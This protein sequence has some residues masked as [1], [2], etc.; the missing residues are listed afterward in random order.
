VN[1]NGKP[2][3]CYV[4]KSN[5]YTVRH[6]A[7]DPEDEALEHETDVETIE[8][9][10]E[11]SPED[12]AGEETPEEEAAEEEAI[13]AV[14]SAPPL[15]MAL[16]AAH[17]HHMALKDYLD[18][19]KDMLERSKAGME[20]EHHA[21]VDQHIAALMEMA[22][23][24][25][26]SANGVGEMFTKR[27]PETD[28][29]QVK[30][31]TAGPSPNQGQPEGLEG[32][33]GYTAMDEDYEDDAV[34]MDE[35]YVSM[36]DDEEE[37]KGEEDAEEILAR[38]REQPK[39]GRRGVRKEYKVVRVEGGYTVVDSQGRRVYEEAM[40]KERAEN[41]AR[42]LQ[43]S[44]G[45][46]ARRAVAKAMSGVQVN[47]AVSVNG[48]HGI[49]VAVD[50]PSQTA[51]VKFNNGHIVTD[52][53]FDDLKWEGGK[54]AR[55]AVAKGSTCMSET[56]ELLRSLAG[57][58]TDPVKRAALEHHAEKMKAAMGAPSGGPPKPGMEPVARAL[59]GEGMEE[60][61]ED[62]EVPEK[63]VR[64]IEGHD[65]EGENNDDPECRAMFR[66][67]S[68]GKSNKKRANGAVAKKL[69]NG[70]ALLSKDASAL[71]DGLAAMKRN[72]GI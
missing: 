17:Q 43:Q 50:K 5:G 63:S 18:E 32:E 24:A 20:P 15:A 35:D 69:T 58:E 67:V 72:L 70:V 21:V 49:V 46:S 60:L 36:S 52:V 48:N 39:G 6:K 65:C 57:S 10:M 16:A 12:F 9:A 13:A 27:Y 37:V 7:E 40:P 55:R 44:G 29:E 4:E 51:D 41:L 47:D 64:K 25:E 22:E 42:G 59:E 30:A 11:E 34:E 1:I 26:E 3:D 19:Q 23:K 66:D 38:Y 8:T 45:K 33:D 31:L 71:T 28:M 54:S 53:S 62:E 14:E 68:S 2:T 56:H 61:D